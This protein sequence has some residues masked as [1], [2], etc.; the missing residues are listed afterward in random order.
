MGQDVNL[1]HFLYVLK[2]KGP[3]MHMQ[4]RQN[5]ICTNPYLI[6]LFSVQDCWSTAFLLISLVE[7]L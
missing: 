4:R 6:P 7:I 2:Y 5:N 1:R 3:Y